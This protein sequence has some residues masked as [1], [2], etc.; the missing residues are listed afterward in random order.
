MLC[1][2]QAN[3]PWCKDKDLEMGNRGSYFSAADEAQLQQGEKDG[4]LA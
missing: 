3:I 1:I 4:L 2:S